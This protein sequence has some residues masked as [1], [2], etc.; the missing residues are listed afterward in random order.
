MIKIGKVHN[1]SHIAKDNLRSALRE[2][3]LNARDNVANGTHK[4]ET[5]NVCIK[6]ELVFDLI[7]RENYQRERKESGDRFFIIFLPIALI[8]MIF[9]ILHCWINLIVMF[10]LR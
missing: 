3:F 8:N 5:F 9:L 2:S 10:F 4:G 7:Y 1:I 6:N